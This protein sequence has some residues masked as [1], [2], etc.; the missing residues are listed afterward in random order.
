MEAEM[1]NAD[2]ICEQSLIVQIKKELGNHPNLPI[3]LIIYNV[4]L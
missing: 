2:D 3:P 1:I 4:R